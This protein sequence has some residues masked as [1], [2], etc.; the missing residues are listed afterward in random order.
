MEDTSA[1][2]HLSGLVRL[3][4]DIGGTFTDF[5]ISDP[6]E[7]KISTFKLL[8]TPENPAQAVL[9]GLDLIKG[10]FGIEIGDLTIIHGSTVATNALLERKGA[11]TALITTRGFRDVLQIGRQN[12]PSL[13]DFSA[14]PPEP[15]VPEHLRLEISERVDHRGNIL[16]PLDESEVDELIFRLKETGVE[17]VA[18]CL[19]F[20]FLHP[21]HEQLIARK[22]RAAGYFVSASVDVLPEYREY[23]RCSTTVVNAYVTPVLSQY[24]ERLQ[25]GMQARLS[26]K[27]EQRN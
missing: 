4:V 14:D 12:R 11:R 13:Y 7:G 21:E 20:S 8:S 27:P 26:T 23:E 25:T 2:P 5:V 10:Q 9:D 19:L 6:E 24:L 15:L 17:S 18:I 3:G 1:Q 22:L 16:N